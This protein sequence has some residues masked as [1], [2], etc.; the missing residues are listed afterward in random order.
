[1][2]VT[3]LAVDDLDKDKWTQDFD[4]QEEE[5]NDYPP[6]ASFSSSCFWR[7]KQTKEG[8]LATDRG[9]EIYFWKPR[10]PLNLT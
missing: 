10:W 1:M 2:V 3:E 7:P 6:P 4:E 8:R 9:D 5:I